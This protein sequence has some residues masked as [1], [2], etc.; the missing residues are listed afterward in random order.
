M[1]EI[2]KPGIGIPIYARKLKKVEIQL[3]KDHK[4]NWGRFLDGH[5][6]PQM[7]RKPFGVAMKAPNSHYKY[8]QSGLS[9][10]Y[11]TIKI[12][13]KLTVEEQN[14]RHSGQRKFQE[15]SCLQ[16][17]DIYV[18]IEYCS[19]SERTQ[20]STRHIEEK[21]EIFAKRFRQGIV[22][23][24]P[25][26][27]VFLKS[28]SEDEKIT[29]YTLG[30]GMN[31]N[32]IENQRPTVRIGAF[33]ISLARKIGRATKVEILFSKLSTRLWPNM[34]L[35]LQKISNY[36]PKTNLVVTLFN[37]D[38]A[39]NNE[40]MQDI[41]VTI[42]LSYKESKALEELR[43]DIDRI[44]SGKINEAIKTRESLVIKRRSQESR[45]YGHKANQSVRNDPN[46][47]SIH[48]GMRPASAKTRFTASLHQSLLLIV[49][50]NNEFKQQNGIRPLS[51]F[52]AKGNRPQTAVTV[53]ATRT[54]DNRVGRGSY[55][56]KTLPR[57]LTAKS[58]KKGRKGK[59]V[60]DLVFTAYA[61]ENNEVEFEG[62]PKGVYQIDS[63]ETPFYQKSTTS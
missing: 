34:P 59:K 30:E 20:V 62:I 8:S 7:H 40:N 13:E 48:S 49:K 24:F 3:K 36:L 41:K 23:K 4:T 51:A 47:L 31:D 45:K 15:I 29:K 28:H 11:K 6:D 39:Y 18:F 42:K 22:E 17:D 54:L 19:N 9:H 43:D 46:K 55:S 35:L 14:K 1:D 53:K 26:I 44:H 63:T 16:N 21:Y 12:L 56:V 32:I 5:Y 50:E 33:E 2:D 37:S 25:F 57:P 52:T 27:K 10:H 61:N 60:D 58:Q 38:D